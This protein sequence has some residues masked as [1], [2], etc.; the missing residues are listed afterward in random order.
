MKRPPARPARGRKRQTPSEMKAA[1][2]ER[3]L[4]NIDAWTPKTDLGKR[5]KLGEIISMD[6]L[7]KEQAK[8]LEYQIIDMLIPELDSELLLIG[9]SKGKFGG[10]AGRIFKQTQ[11][12][13]REGNKPSFA[14]C[15]VVGNK[16]GLVGLGYG[17]AK[18]TVPAREKAIRNAKINMMTIPRGSG[19]W[20]SESTVPHTIPFKVTGK[21]GSVTVTLMPAPVG[22]G[23][24]VESECKKILELAGIKNVWSKTIGHTATKANIIKA[25]HNALEKLSQMKIREQDYAALNIVVGSTKQGKRVHI[26]DSGTPEVKAE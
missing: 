22:T 23:L 3:K 11:K 21:C 16:D 14:T 18:E 25:C 9:Q 7:L 2:Q 19:D 8:V 24:I 6:E 4:A 12:K 15:A 26:E 20:E 10:G 1:A 5:V 17:K 13:T